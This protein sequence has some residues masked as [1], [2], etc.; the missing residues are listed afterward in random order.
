M[1]YKKLWKILQELGIPDH[2]ICLLRNLCSG[3]EAR[4][5]TRY[6]TMDW[7]QIGKGL[8]QG[9]QPLYLTYMQS[10]SCKMPDWMKHKLEL[11][12]KGE[13]SITSDMQMTPPYRKWKITEEPRDESRR[14]EWEKLAKN[15][16]FKKLRSWH[17]LPSLYTNRWGNNG[18][19]QRLYILGLQNHCRWW[20]QPCN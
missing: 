8:C 2:L 9:C 15:S 11:R 20:L 7:F 3:Q 19:S 4:V 5:R 10:T 18:K 17:L 16:M 6:E 12:L 13:K 14:G 1:H